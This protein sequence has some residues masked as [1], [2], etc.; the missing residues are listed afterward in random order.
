VARWRTSAAAAALLLVATA[1]GHSSGSSEPA[2]DVTTIRPALAP[3]GQ[4]PLTVTGT[5][6][7]PHEKVM[8]AAKGA[9]SA[10]AKVTADESG[11]FTASFHGLKACDSVTVT[12]VGSK[13]SRTEFNLSQIACID[14]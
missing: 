14:A 2:R 5:S 8:L 4:S 1:C 12:A 9:Q 6:F 13:G 10:S 11:S 3:I 7:R